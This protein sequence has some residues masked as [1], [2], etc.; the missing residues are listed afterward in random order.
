MFCIRL[1]TIMYKF[2]SIFYW[3]LVFS[4][5][6]TVFPPFSS[7]KVDKKSNIFCFALI[8]ITFDFF[9]LFVICVFVVYP[10]L[11]IQ[12]GVRLSVVF[13]GEFL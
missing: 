1:L 12:S 4:S 11:F 10:K 5:K 2:Y 13:I 3:L 8:I 6:P 9:Y 7:N